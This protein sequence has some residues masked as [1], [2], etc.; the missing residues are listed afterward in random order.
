M[1]AAK[2]QSSTKAQKISK[3]MQAYLQ[4]AQEHDF[5][6]KSE[7]EEFEMGKR[8]LANIM[9]QD[10]DL[11]EQADIDKAIEYL[12]PSGLFEKRARPILKDPYEVFPKKKVAEFAADGRPFQ[13]LFYTGKPNFYAILLKASMTLEELKQEETR[14]QRKDQMHEVADK[15]LGF[16]GSDWIKQDTLK[17]LTIEP[18]TDHDHKHFVVLMTRLAEHPLS[19]KVEDFI[20]QYRRNLTVHSFGTDIPKPLIAEDG[21]SYAEGSAKRKTSM[22]NVKLYNKGTGKFSV[23]GQGLLYFRNV[24]H[25][26]Q[27]MAPLVVV[28]RLGEVDIEAT[29]EG[30]GGTGQSGAVRLAIAN[31]LLPFVDTDTREKMRIA[32]LLT[33]DVRRRERKKPGQKKARKKFTWKKR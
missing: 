23:N 3:A 6:M 19:F 24:A 18:V 29:V 30:G 15:K 12:L 13:S 25:R 17:D 33:R 4:R 14:L 8:H 32:G 21:R 9:G 7:V 20:M 16:H 22:A 26:E 10:P 1:S 2:S 11:F 28:G 27:I 31:A 5:K